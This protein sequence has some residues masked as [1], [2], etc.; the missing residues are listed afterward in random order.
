[1]YAVVK[2]G[3][4][5]YRVEPGK[6]LEV[7]L[8]EGSTGDEVTFSEVLLVEKD[9]KTVVGQPFVKGASVKATITGEKRAAKVTIFKK[10]RRHGQQL[11]KGHRQNLTLVMIDSVNV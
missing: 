2:T 3:G 4:K 5:Q 7:E 11:K 9:G 10:L 8:L 1:M 6:T